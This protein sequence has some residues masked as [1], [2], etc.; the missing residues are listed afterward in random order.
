MVKRIEYDRECGDYAGYINEQIAAF[1]RT[2]Y[3]VECKLNEI[4]YQRLT[5]QHGK[6]K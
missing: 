5:R 2:F 1:G 3:E 4:I 6:L